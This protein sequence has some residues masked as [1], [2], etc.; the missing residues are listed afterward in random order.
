[1]RRATADTAA[2]RAIRHRCRAH[3]TARPA[4]PTDS[5]R[6]LSTETTVSSACLTRELEALA[7]EHLAHRVAGDDVARLAFEQN[8]ARMN[9]VSAIDDRQRCVHVV[10]R[11]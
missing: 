2:I 10:I 5:A 9:D 4:C 1:M 11:H 7:Q 8:L 6:A 3:P